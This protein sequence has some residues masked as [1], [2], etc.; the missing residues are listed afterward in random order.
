VVPELSLS[1]ALVEARL[2]SQQNKQVDP[3]YEP[4]DADWLD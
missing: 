4:T 3:T 2:N 1:L